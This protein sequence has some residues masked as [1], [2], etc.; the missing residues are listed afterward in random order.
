M[1]IIFTR[2]DFLSQIPLTIGRKMT[3]RGDRWHA[4]TLGNKNTWMASVSG[5]HFT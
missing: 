1:I 5:Y 2:R 4:T 3:I